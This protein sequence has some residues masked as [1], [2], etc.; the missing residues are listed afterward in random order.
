MRRPTGHVSLVVSCRA[1]RP[2]APAAWSRVPVRE[3]SGSSPR[4]AA[5]SYTAC[6]MS[7]RMVRGTGG[8]GVGSEE[9]VHPGWNPWSEEVIAVAERE[10]EPRPSSHDADTVRTLEE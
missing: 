10:N 9:Q 1:G 5:G 4:C 6:P 7:R 8:V 3:L 2:D